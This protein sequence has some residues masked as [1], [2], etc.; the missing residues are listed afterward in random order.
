VGFALGGETS[1]EGGELRVPPEGGGESGVEEGVAQALSSAGD[2]ALAVVVAGVVVI[3]CEA[4][5]SG[6][7]LAG[8][9]AD[10]WHADED[11]DGGAQA[12]ARDAFDE[13]EAL[14]EVWV[15]AEIGDEAGELPLELLF[16][17]ADL[18]I[19]VA[20]DGVVAAGGA[21]GLQPG[22]ILG[23]LLDQGEMLGPGGAWMSSASQSAVQAA[24]RVASMR[25]F[26]ARCSRYRA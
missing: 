20:E 24:I 14:G 3:G 12:D 22:D 18:E 7:F 25:S 16:E 6:G 10:L 19:P 11:G 8:E 4:G 23:D 2:V 21:S 9:G 15:L 26:L 5:E 1:V 17:A 13:I